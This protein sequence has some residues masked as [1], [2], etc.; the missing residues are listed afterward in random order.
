ML[1]QTN[2]EFWMVYGLGQKQP[3]VRHKSFRSAQA[4]A[5]RLAKLNPEIPF[6][7]LVPISV[8]IKIEVETAFLPISFPRV[9]DDVEI[10]F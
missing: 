5:K 1:Q 6:Y 4:E 9:D 8:S 2:T 7:V 3:T 10:P